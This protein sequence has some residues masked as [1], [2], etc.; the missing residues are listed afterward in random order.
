M[1]DEHH[2]Y[3]EKENDIY[4]TD[5]ITFSKICHITTEAIDKNSV[6]LD[7]IDNMLIAKDHIIICGICQNF[8]DFVKPLRAKY[9]PKSKCLTIVILS[10][11]LPDDKLWSSIAFFDQIYLIL[12]DPMNKNDLYRAGIRSAKK[13]VIL[14]PSIQE[15]NSFAN[16]SKKQEENNKYIIL[17]IELLGN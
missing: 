7:T 12:G 9:L 15:I 17:T 4:S 10:K 8:I 13:V 2:S 14:A 5:A 11:D 6:T 16:L 1:D 3:E